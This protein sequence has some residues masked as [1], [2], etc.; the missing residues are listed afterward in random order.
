MLAYGEKLEE[1]QPKLL[2]GLSSWG[3][4]LGPIAIGYWLTPGSHI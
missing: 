1:G 3:E 2:I 4:W